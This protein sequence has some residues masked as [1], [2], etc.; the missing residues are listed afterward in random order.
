MANPWTREVPTNW[1]P[2]VG[3]EILK[4]I[5]RQLAEDYN[6]TGGSHNDPPVQDLLFIWL[7]R[8]SD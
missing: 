4:E 7:R 3:M 5:S 6:A 2:L 8:V 1:F